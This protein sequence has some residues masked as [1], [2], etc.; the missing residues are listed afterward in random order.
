MVQSKIK[1]LDVQYGSYAVQKGN[2]ALISY[3]NK[4]LC[5]E[6]K[7]GTLEKLYKK[8]FGTKTFV[9]VPA[10]DMTLP[11]ATTDV[12]VVGGGP[13]GLAAAT[14]VAAAGLSVTLVD[15]RVTL[16]G[17]IYKRMGLG[18]E[19]DDPRRSAASTWPAAI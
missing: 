10:A 14:K 19:V 16:G 11:R 18:F 4:F 8:D 17:Q 9:G 7:N 15:E 5:T 6:S 3:L 12:L 13:A 1:P 2:T